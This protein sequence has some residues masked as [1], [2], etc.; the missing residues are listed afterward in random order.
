MN[1]EMLVI[2]K[3]KK[4]KNACSQ[5]LIRR[6]K[7]AFTSQSIE[8]IS[9]LLSDP[10]RKS[11]NALLVNAFIRG[12][13]LTKTVTCLKDHVTMICE[14]KIHEIQES[15]SLKK[16][17]SKILTL[18]GSV[19]HPSLL[20][21]NAHTSHMLCVKFPEGLISSVFKGRHITEVVIPQTS[22][23]LY[24]MVQEEVLEEVTKVWNVG[25]RQKLPQEVISALLVIF[26]NAA[27]ENKSAGLRTVP[28]EKKFTP[29]EPIIDQILAMGFT[30]KQAENA[31]NK[32]KL[33][34]L[35]IAMEWLLS[36]P[37]EAAEDQRGLHESP[38]PH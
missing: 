5:S 6:A 7:L 14:D 33:N 18:L 13:V 10:R 35:E 17:I 20:F 29:A 11:C 37:E 30:R 12:S 25:L 22:N 38:P 26:R 15:N 32:V 36:H 1:L 24:L 28:K 19:L 16:V 8:E 23:E 2:D 9:I 21:A 3:D 31:L 4:V 34:N 27:Q